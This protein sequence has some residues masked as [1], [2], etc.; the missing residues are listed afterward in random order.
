MYLILF[1]KTFIEAEAGIKL[2][3]RVQQQKQVL[4][5][6]FSDDTSTE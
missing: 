5:T 3:V 2:Q 4:S 6:H 1:K